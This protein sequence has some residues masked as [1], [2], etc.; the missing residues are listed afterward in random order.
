MEPL[1]EEYYS[2]DDPIDTV[3]ALVLDEARTRPPLLRGDVDAAVEARR[4]LEVEV[5]EAITGD[6]G[7]SANE[8]RVE[9]VI[10]AVREMLYLDW[11]S[12]T[13]RTGR[14]V[15]NEATV[16]AALERYRQYKL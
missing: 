7:V 12:G 11:P 2:T 10:D 9:R 15:P 3:I 6:S 5:A 4:Q 13:R 16:R 1:A 8:P 14:D